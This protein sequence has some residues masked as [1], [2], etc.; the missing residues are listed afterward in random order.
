M[1]IEKPELPSLYTCV[2]SRDQDFMLVR[3]VPSGSV[4]GYK[5]YWEVNCWLC[6]DTFQFSRRWDG[7]DK[8]ASKP[9]RL[10]SYCSHLG[11]RPSGSPR[12]PHGRFK[13]G[14]HW[15]VVHFD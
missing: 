7:Y 1:Q 5:C 6:G 4:Y 12:Y 14:N 3:V 9:R 15:T 10:C 8:L 2:V 11:T 13:L